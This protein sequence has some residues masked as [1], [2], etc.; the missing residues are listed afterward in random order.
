MSELV[1][2]QVAIVNLSDFDG[3]K[4]NQYDCKYIGKAENRVV[5]IVHKF[6]DND[7]YLTDFFIGEFMEENNDYIHYGFLKVLRGNFKILV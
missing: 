6:K 2:K 5:T 4:P 1:G 7:L 3:N